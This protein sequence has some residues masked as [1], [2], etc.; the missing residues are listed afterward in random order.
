M[1]ERYAVRNERILAALPPIV[2]TAL[3][4]FGHDAMHAEAVKRG[5][6]KFLI[7]HANWALNKLD[8]E[9]QRD[10]LRAGAFIEYVTVSCVSPIFYEQKP[11]EL[12]TKAL[13]EV[14]RRVFLH[15]LD[16]LA[17]DAARGIDFLD[18]HLFDFVERLLA[19]GHE[20]G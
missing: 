8:V 17:Q 18:G 9:T 1:S 14:G 15:R 10:F 4:Y 13:V 5:V 6:G 20:A 11:A 12:Y 3:R 16:G 19:D 7:T 2:A